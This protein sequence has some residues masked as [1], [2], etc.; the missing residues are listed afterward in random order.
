MEFWFCNLHV[1]RG[2]ARI[3]VDVVVATSIGQWTQKKTATFLPKKCYL[4]EM[5]LSV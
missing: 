1:S 3:F 4:C 2:F 5:I